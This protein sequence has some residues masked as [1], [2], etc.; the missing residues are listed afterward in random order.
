MYPVL[1]FQEREQGIAIS[2]PY[3]QPLG[4]SLDGYDYNLMANKKREPHILSS[5]NSFLLPVKHNT[6]YSVVHI[7]VLPL[8]KICSPL[9]A[10]EI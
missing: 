9:W 4:M 8:T 3:S 10:P 6:D 1:P 7:Q 5:G 2:L